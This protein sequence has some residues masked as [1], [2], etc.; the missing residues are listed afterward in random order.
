M[1]ITPKTTV[2]PTPIIAYSEPVRTPLTT[3]W[4]NVSTGEGTTSFEDDDDPMDGWEVTGPPEGSDP[5]PND[6]RRTGSVGY[7]EGAA[8]STDDSLYFGFGLEGVSGADERAEI[9]GRSM[10]FLQG[11]G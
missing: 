8:T 1:R 5:N 2:S 6:W 4:T 9:M 7:S 3:L 11:D 10:G